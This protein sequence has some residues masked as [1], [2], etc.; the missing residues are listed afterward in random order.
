MFERDNKN[1]KPDKYKGSRI[2]KSIYI[3]LT[4]V[5][6]IVFVFYEGATL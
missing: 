1:I 3:S 2:V 4:F 6:L 5:E